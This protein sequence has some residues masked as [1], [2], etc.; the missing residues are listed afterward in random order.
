M[1]INDKIIDSST[2]LHLPIQCIFAYL[3]C[4]FHI[5][6]PKIQWNLQNETGEVLLKTHT[7]ILTVRYP[8]GAVRKVLLANI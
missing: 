2:N 7:D 6:P 3:L 4:K 8:T 1:N 5:I